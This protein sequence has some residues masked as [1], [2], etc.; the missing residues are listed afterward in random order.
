MMQKNLY[1]DAIELQDASNASGVV[2]WLSREALPFIWNEIRQ[3][4]GTGT[5]DVNAHPIMV[6]TVDKLA[7]LAHMNDYG[8][9]SLDR[10]AEAYRLCEQRA[11]AIRKANRQEIEAA[12]ERDIAAA[13]KSMEAGR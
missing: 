12:E 10:Y 6:L 3:E 2:H 13:E 8:S 1:Q 7:S 9:T 11:E 5:A 4:D